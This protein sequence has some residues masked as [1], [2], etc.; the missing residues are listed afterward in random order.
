VPEVGPIRLFDADMR[1][2]DGPWINPIRDLMHGVAGAAHSR[3]ASLVLTGEGGDYILD[4]YHYLEDLLRHRRFGRFV[5]G[6][7]QSASWAGTGP[8]DVLGQPLRQVAPTPVKRTYRRFVPAPEG[9]QWSLAGRHPLPRQGSR[10]SISEAP[11]ASRSQQVL[12]GDL[13]HPMVAW[14]NE[15]HASTF[16]AHGLDI[17]HPF[18]DRDL[19]EF[20]ASIHPLDLPFD[21]RS[22]TL[23]RQG[24]DERL[25]RSVLGRRSKTTF[26]EYLAVCLRQHHD[27]YAERFAAVPAHSV[28]F[29]DTAAYTAA[30]SQFRADQLSASD[31]AALRRAWHVIAWID[32]IGQRGSAND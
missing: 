7:Y 5:R 23:V 3:D 24:F 30:L 4:Q 6:V 18:F 2:A 27:A 13:G 31:F 15:V 21:G 32:L 22:K 11:H 28:G 17:S 16:A 1:V 8:I 25:P 20:V 26:D 12:L 29:V 19:A 10:S 9:L 14:I